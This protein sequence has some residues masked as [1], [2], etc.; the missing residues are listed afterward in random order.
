M[1]NLIQLDRKLIF[2]YSLF[3]TVERA[4]PAYNNMLREDRQNF[5]METL[6]QY[7]Y[8][9]AVKISGNYFQLD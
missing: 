5:N 3:T 8:I 6:R 2:V 4:F 7:L 9:Y 1:P